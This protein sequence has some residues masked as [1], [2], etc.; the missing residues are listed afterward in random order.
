M[1]PFLSEAYI[2]VKIYYSH[3]S[4]ER[5]INGNDSISQTCNKKGFSILI[6]DVTVQT[7]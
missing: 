2:L 6:L 4:F 7:T 5:Q 1:F 3:L